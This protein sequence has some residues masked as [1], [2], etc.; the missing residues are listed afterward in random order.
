MHSFT[1]NQDAALGEPERKF[2]GVSSLVGDQVVTTVPAR[3][4]SRVMQREESLVPRLGSSVREDR[5]HRRF[6]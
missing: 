2:D 4:S 3:T 5:R 6:G 1:A